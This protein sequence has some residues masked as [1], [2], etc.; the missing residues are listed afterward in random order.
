MVRIIKCKCSCQEFYVFQDIKDFIWAK[1]T[2]C[3]FIKLIGN[4]K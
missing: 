4:N 2:A 3:N 1:C